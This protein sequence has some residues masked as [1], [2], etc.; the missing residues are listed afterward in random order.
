MD[1]SILVIEDGAP[2]RFTLQQ[3]LLSEGY[4]VSL[5]ENGADALTQ[6]KTSPNT[7]SLSKIRKSQSN[8]CERFFYPVSVSYFAEMRR[9]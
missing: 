4:E 1:K 3:L 7:T 2:I 5:A 8:A 9:P 6:L